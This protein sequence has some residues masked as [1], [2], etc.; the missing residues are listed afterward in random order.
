MER[1]NLTLLRI[2]PVSL[3]REERAD[4]ALARRAGLEEIIRDRAS[5]ALTH[6]RIGFSDAYTMDGRPSGPP[7][8]TRSS[9]A[10]TPYAGISSLD[11]RTADVLVSI[12]YV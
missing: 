2:S 11:V 1:R 5:A 7:R 8:A 6:Q 12:S 3:T 10:A 9:Q 4:I